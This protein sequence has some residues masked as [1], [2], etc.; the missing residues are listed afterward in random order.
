MSP[1]DVANLRTVSIHIAQ[2][3]LRPP[4]S[5][6]VRN[7]AEPRV[8]NLLLRPLHLPIDSVGLEF[9]HAPLDLPRI[10]TS[11][12]SHLR[13]LPPPRTSEQISIAESS[14]GSSAQEPR[15]R[16]GSNEICQPFA[17]G[18]GLGLAIGSSLLGGSASCSGARSNILA[19]SL[20]N[21]LQPNLLRGFEN[22]MFN[23]ELDICVNR[24][25]TLVLA[26]GRRQ[27]ARNQDDG[28]CC[29]LLVRTEEFAAAAPCVTPNATTPSPPRPV[30]R[31]AVQPADRA[32][33]T[34]VRR[35]CLLR[36]TPCVARTR[37]CTPPLPP[38]SPARGERHWHRRGS[39]HRLRAMA[40]YG[41]L[42]QWSDY[43]AL[44]CWRRSRGTPD[45]STS[46]T[47]APSR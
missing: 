33:R 32:C 46:S 15:L 29:E 1:S 10:P 5:S 20:A 38:S 25:T 37:A 3:P 19:R 17:S 14:G 47:A 40:S 26:K 39:G 4:S 7:R 13:L 9:L 30:L 42:K 41:Q 18:L 6:S 16:W 2:L 28:G 8:A 36:P 23:L 22:P 11:P 35:P 12:R 24:T 34:A 27:V 44:G 43:A 21:S 31:G 45:E